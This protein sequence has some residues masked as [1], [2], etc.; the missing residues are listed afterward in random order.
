MI[1][2][3]LFDLGGTLYDYQTLARSSRES[4]LALAHWAGVNAAP[5]EVTRSHRDAMRRVFNAY[6]P[7]SFYLHRDLFRDALI[8][9][10]AEFGAGLEQTHLERYEALLQRTQLRDLEL[11]E[12]AK[13]TLRA[14]R[15]RGLTLGIVSNIDEDQLAHLTEAGGLQPYF[16]WTLSSENAGS[17]KPDL[18]IF[19]LAL[20]RSRCTAEEALFVGDTLRQDIE[21]ANRAGMRSV[22]LW[23]R[24]DREPPAGQVQP[25]HVIRRIPELLRLLG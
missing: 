2:A 10:L 14:L 20:R 3:V 16:D 17:C 8:E 22:L 15:A 24:G 9:M 18:R 11:R 6:L 13:E 1:K 12:G 7:R 19:E 23:Y 25:N 21:G 4:L 5:D